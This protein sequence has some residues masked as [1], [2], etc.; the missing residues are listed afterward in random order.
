MMRKKLF[1]GGQWVEGKTYAPLYSPYSGEQIAE[2]PVASQEETDQA[3][4][5]AYEARSAMR[6]MPAHQ[7]AQILQKVSALFK[8]RMEEAAKLVALEAA[9][10]IRTARTEITRT[11][12]TYQF[13]AEEA[14]R[15]G[16]E[17]LPLDA[18]VGGE[19]RLA[20][21]KRE[22]LGVI[23]AITPFNFP[24]N[25]VAHKVGPAIATGNTVVLKPASQ[26]PLS[27]FFLAEL[28]EEAGLPKGALNVVT[29]GGR[30][31]G[32]QLVQDPRLGMITFTGSP[33]VGIGI[34]NQAGLKRVTLELG[35]NS[36]AIVDHTVRDHLDW[37]VDRCVM[38][39]FTYQGQVCISLQRIYVHDKLY[40]AFVTQ[41]VE[42]T[43]E[44]VW[45]DPLSEET[46]ISA[47]I[48]PQDVERAL[49]WIEEAVEGGAEIA[50]GGEREGN[51]LKP[52]VLLNVDPTLKVSCREVFAPIVLINRIQTV[53][54]GL[55]LVND[56]RY[57][58]QAGLFTANLMLALDGA[59][60]LEVGGVM[61][62]DIPTFRVDHMPYGG[63]KESGFGREGIQYAVEEMTELKLVVVNRSMG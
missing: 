11:I 46:D 5:A 40:D 12:Q 41:F 43:K 63:V 17:V 9:K 59:D 29:G 53:E 34:K 13:A 26:T 7:R 27:A 47:L 60:K 33:E 16:G 20:Y 8:E 21:T 6:A 42:K 52:T 56:S 3:I 25:L 19:G 54:E 38:G 51:I 49:Q 10:P 4:S 35:S 62:N 32:Q 15:I 31:V 23:G 14:K 28:F 50:C 37:I 2:V 48:T 18:A 30:T 24:M 39:A 22:P 57:G 55:A 61:I 1:I 58:L 45:G 36:A 44:L